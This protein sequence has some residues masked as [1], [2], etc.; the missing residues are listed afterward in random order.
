[1]ANMITGIGIPGFLLLEMLKTVCTRTALTPWKN[2]NKTLK[3]SFVNKSQVFSRV[4]ANTMK[5]CVCVAGQGKNEFL[6][7]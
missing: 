6:H 4:S 2:F 1:M 3:E 5:E 7:R